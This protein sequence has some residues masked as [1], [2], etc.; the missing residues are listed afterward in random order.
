MNKLPARLA[1]LTM[2]D[3]AV[4]GAGPHGLATA[5]H[6]RGAGIDVRVFGEVMGFWRRN[7]PV[8]MVLRS[9]RPGSHIPDPNHALTLEQFESRLGRKFPPR[10]ALEDFIAYG[11]W[12][13][14]EAVPAVDSRIVR[15]VESRGG[16]FLLTICDGDLV[17]AKRV[18]MATG[19]EAFASRPAAFDRIPCRTRDALVSIARPR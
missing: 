12:F 2:C 4:I 11:T 10:M 5:A 13:Q 1:T 19:L 9:E 14:Q 7:M 18:V 8:G 16:S 6:L 17:E 3:V 15:Q